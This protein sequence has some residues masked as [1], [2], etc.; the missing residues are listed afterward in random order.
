ME[1][2]EDGNNR[3]PNFPLQLLERKEDDTGQVSGFF[4]GRSGQN[5][6]YFSGEVSTSVAASQSESQE[7]VKKPPAKRASNK[8]RHTK[9][10][11][12]GRRIRMPATCAARVFQL[13]RELGHKSDGETIEWLLQQAEP[14]VIAATGTGTIPANFSSLNI[15]LRSSAASLAAPVL[16][17][18]YFHPSITQQLIARPEPWDHDPSRRL[19]LGSSIP[20]LSQ[21]TATNSSHLGLSAQQLFSKPAFHDSDIDE[22]DSKKRRADLSEQSSIGG[23][24]LQAPTVSAGSG[25]LPATFWML[26]SQASSQVGHSGLMQTE[27][28]WTYPSGPGT[29][30][31]AGG[32]LHF[33]NFPGPVALPIGSGEVLQALN[34]YAPARHHGPDPDPPPQSRGHEPTGQD[35]SE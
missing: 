28:T 30:Y 12:R 27:P 10:E 23:Y 32:G 1:T 19:M 3:R 13:T 33:M 9:V 5:S 31:R 34:S 25:Q 35:R 24:A 26:A 14:A 21:Q 18:S 29:L 7:T 8:D 22:T 16:K 4:S 2:S 15:S 20:N 17:S 11:G 6:G